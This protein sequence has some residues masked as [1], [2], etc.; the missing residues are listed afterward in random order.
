[1]KRLITNPWLVG[2]VTTLTALSL[3]WFWSI[4]PWISVWP[5]V[6]GGL[7]LVAAVVILVW[8]V[9]GRWHSLTW[10]AAAG[11]ILVVETCWRAFDL[12]EA[13]RFYQV[14]AWISAIGL[15]GVSGYFSAAGWQ[16]GLRTGLASQITATLGWS[17]VL[18]LGFGQP[19]MAAALD[20]GGSLDRFAHTPALVFWTWVAEDLWGGTAVR[21]ALAAGWGAGLGWCGEWVRGRFPGLLGLGR[22]GKKD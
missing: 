6:S 2:M 1:M 22:G 19:V 17:V 13:G 9:P 10:G 3:F 20:L 11:L 5:V 4:A 14:L 21:L 8:L 7:A 16:A 12:P 18:G 15:T